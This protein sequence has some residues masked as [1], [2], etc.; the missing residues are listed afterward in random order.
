LIELNNLFLRLCA[1]EAEVM[2]HFELFLKQNG[3]GHAITDLS[4]LG[5]FWQ[6]NLLEK[7]KKNTRIT[8]FSVRY[9]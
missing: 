9:L 4:S 6:M 5:K 1:D 7:F 2:S 8:V 3:G